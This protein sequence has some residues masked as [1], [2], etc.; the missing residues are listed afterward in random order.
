MESALYYTFSTIAQVL[1]C[2]MT[3]IAAFV[4]F[5]MDSLNERIKKVQYS[6]VVHYLPNLDLE[7]HI[8]DEKQKLWKENP[9]ILLIRFFV[10]PH[11]VIGSS[12]IAQFHSLAI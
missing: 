4:L 9:S 11:S 2:A 6:A 8:N 10:D 7:K 3:L 12:S 5:R 1:G